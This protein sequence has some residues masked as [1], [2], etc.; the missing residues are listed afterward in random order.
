MSKSAA[1]SMEER[2]LAF[3]RRRGGGVS[4]AELDEHI[5]GFEAIEGDQY[6]LI[7]GDFPNVVVWWASRE[8]I[9]AISGLMSKRKVCMNSTSHLT[10]VADGKIPRL[11]LARRVQEYAKPHWLPATLSLLT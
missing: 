11:P 1:A 6:K 10:Y 3:V 2:I 4:F 8:A 5:K 7:L 9:E